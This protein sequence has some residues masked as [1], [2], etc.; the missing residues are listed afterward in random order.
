M[1]KASA[2]HRVCQVFGRLAVRWDLVV[3]GVARNDGYA[4]KPLEV[5]RVDARNSSIHAR[6]HVGIRRCILTGA[7][8]P[9]CLPQLCGINSAVECQL[10]K[11]KV[12]G[13]NPVSR[14]RL[15]W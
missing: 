12:A 5:S 2:G 14:S 9:V 15:Q 7:G 13:S 11:L 1:V 10:P 4:P 8:L 6:M 3:C